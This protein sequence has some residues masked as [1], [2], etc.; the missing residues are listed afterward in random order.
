MS[1]H[2][3]A[4]K[5]CKYFVNG[6]NCP[7]EDVGCMFLHN[8]QDLAEEDAN[9]ESNDIT[10]PGDLLCL[11]CHK[12]IGTQSNLIEHMSDEHIEHFPHIQPETDF[13]S[14]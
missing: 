14:F 2:D 12:F 1:A 8:D 3:T 4:T 7:F 6:T 5:P 11:I 13:I 10:A 9:I